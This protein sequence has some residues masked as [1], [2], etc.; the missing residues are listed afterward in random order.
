MRAS[1]WDPKAIEDKAPSTPSLHRFMRD[2]KDI[3]NEPLPGIHVSSCEDD[4]SK[5]HVIVVG[6]SG[7]P[8]EGGFFHFFVKCSQS[9]PMRPPL[10]RLLTTDAGRVR[11]NPNLYACGKVCLSILGTQ[12]GP[13]WN[14][15]QTIS[16]V[17]LSIQSLFKEEPYCNEPQLAE[18]FL[19]DSA[20]YKQRLQHETIRVAVCD[21][22]E[23]CM[24]DNSPCP[25]DLAAVVISTFA[26]SYDKYEDKV[27]S[28]L[29]LTG[30]KMEKCFVG[31]NLEEAT[32]QYETLLRRLMELNGGNNRN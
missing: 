18:A 2:I 28:L 8:Y 32:F 22:V 16:S 17:L 15:V 7:T 20:G 24:Q 5:L 13:A 10:V 25:Q 29:H 6:P 21:A 23:A 11:F 12:T 31:P 26:D 9:Y 27:K 19:N 3:K 30:T 4:L 1:R 14:P